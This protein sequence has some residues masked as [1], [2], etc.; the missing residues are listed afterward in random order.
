MKAALGASFTVAKG[1]TARKARNEISARTSAR[2]FSK[3]LASSIEREG[4]VDSSSRQIIATL[5]VN[6]RLRPDKRRSTLIT[7]KLTQ[8]REIT[9]LCEDGRRGHRHRFMSGAART[10]GLAWPGRP[11]LRGV[12]LHHMDGRIKSGHDD[13]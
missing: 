9:R 4:T 13:C 11:R 7:N 5:S 10:T 2:R 3:E 6:Y 1:R 12:L 8:R